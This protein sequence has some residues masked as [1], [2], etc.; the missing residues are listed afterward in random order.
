MEEIMERKNGWEVFSTEEKNNVFKFCDEY[1]EFISRNKIE[2]KLVNECVETAEKNGFKEINKYKNLKKGDKFYK[3][4]K[5]KEVIFGIIGKE[6][7]K[8]GAKFIVSHIDSPRLDLKTSPIYEDENIC[9]LKTYYYGGIKKYQ[10]LTIPLALYG[11]VILKTGEKIEIEI[12]EKEN[13]SIFTITDLLPHLSKDQYKKTIEE[14][15]PGEN[16]NVLFGTIPLTE[17]T[18]EKEKVKKNVIK[19]LKEK[20]GIEESDFI[21]SELHFVPAGKG[22]DAGIDKSMI[23]SYGQDDRVCSYT[24]FRAINEI[25]NPIKSVFCILVDQEEIGSYGTTSAQSSFFRYLIEEVVEKTGGTLSDIRE[26]FENSKA[27][28][29]DVD[30]LL[31]PNFKEVSDPRNTARIN[32]GVVLNKTTGG[33]GKGGSIEPSAE[34][35]G[36]IRKIFDQNN[37]LWQTGEIGK[38][39]QGGGGTVATYFARYNIDTIDCG[40]GVLSMHAPFELTGK[41]DIYSTYRAY[42][43]FFYEE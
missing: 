3:K 42:K 24:S 39:E 40:T 10:W 5:E 7:L 20:Y 13:E 11:I 18:E 8:K 17:K 21:S 6:I 12:G 25:E 14:G 28:S 23:L 1:K 34:Y 26:L 19:I 15:F 43:I 27:I 29:A 41:I 4:N 9:L 2:R 35:I 30:S 38:I 37:V 32:C 36:Y 33:R 31:D 22:R 16:L